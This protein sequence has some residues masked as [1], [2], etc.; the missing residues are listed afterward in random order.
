L[1][2]NH[3]KK[4]IWSKYSRTSVVA[5]IIQDPTSAV[6]IKIRDR[7]SVVLIKIRDRTSVVLIIIRDPTSVAILN[8]GPNSD[9]AEQSNRSYISNYQENNKK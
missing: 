3:I 5:K 7:T 8:L 1:S 4:S 6:T 2:Y 9:A